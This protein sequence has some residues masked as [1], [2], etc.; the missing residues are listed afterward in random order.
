MRE[1]EQNTLTEIEK[2]DQGSANT[3]QFCSEL[4][5]SFAYKKLL[6]IN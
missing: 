4:E 3:K 6:V 1:R 5:K 2:I